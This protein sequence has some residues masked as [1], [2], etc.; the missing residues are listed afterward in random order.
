MENKKS[1]VTAVQE[2]VRQYAG[3][4]G[5]IYY[6]TIKFENGD[7]GQYGSKSQT[8]EK[9]ITGQEAEYTIE[10]KVNGQYTNYTIKP[11]ATSSFFGGGAKSAKDDSLIVAQTCLKAAVDFNSNNPAATPQGVTEDAQ[12]FF[13]WVMTHKSK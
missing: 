1:K 8:C 7:S 12:I 10:A 3:Q 9:F 6:H 11:V 13:N 5:T 2:N 4:N